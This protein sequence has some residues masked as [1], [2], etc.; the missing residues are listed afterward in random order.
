M[1]CFLNSSCNRAISFIAILHLVLLPFLSIRSSYASLPIAPDGSTNTV[2][3]RSA[4]GIDIV[5]IAAPDSG[6]VSRNNFQDYNVNKSG[7][8]INNASVRDY[9]NGAV[10]TNIAG[11]VLTNSH[12]GNSG[13]ARVILNQVTSNRI[14]RINGYSEIAGR[15]ANLV[16]ANPNGIII[17]GGGFINTDRLG[18]V[19]GREVGAADSNIAINNIDDN[20]Y[21]KITASPHLESG[22]LPKLTISDNGIDLTSVDRTS[23]VANLVEINAGIYADNNKVKI[24]TGD[25]SYSYHKDEVS[26]IDSID[27]PTPSDDLE[28]DEKIAIDAAMLSDIQA[29]DIFLVAT[30]EGFGV[31]YSGAMLASNGEIKVSAD[32]DIYYEN[33]N[34]AGESFISNSQGNITFDDSDTAISKNTEINADNVAIINDSNIGASNIIINVEKDEQDNGNI[35]IDQSSKI[36]SAIDNY[37]NFGDLN[38][39]ANSDINNAGQIISE[40]A[41]SLIVNNGD[42]NLNSSSILSSKQAM[43]LA[44]NNGNIN[45]YDGSEIISGS[46]LSLMASTGGIKQLSKNSVIVHGDHIITANDYINTGK[47]DILGNLTMNIANNLINGSSDDGDGQ[48]AMIFA[49]NDVSLNIGN[50]LINNKYSA[51]YAGNN[52]NIRKLDPNDPN[53]DANNNAVNKVE[54]ISAEIIANNGDINI[55]TK[56]LNNIRSEYRYV[57]HKV[58]PTHFQKTDRPDLSSLQRDIIGNIVNEA[59]IA[60]G[61]NII[62]NTEAF[63]N[64]ASS[65]YAKNDITINANSFINETLDLHSTTNMRAGKK[66]GSC[67]GYYFPIVICYGGGSWYYRQAMVPSGH[68]ERYTA[69]IKAG[70]SINGTVAGNI[71]N[72]T[73]V[74]NYLVTELLPKKTITTSDPFSISTLYESGQLEFD[75]SNYFAGGDT[76]GLIQKSSN[77]NSPLFE[78]RS[79][80]IDQD[81][82]FVSDYFYDKLGINLDDLNTQI[83]QSNSRFIGDQYFQAKIISDQLRSIAR[84]SMLLSADQVDANVEMKNLVDN[85]ADESVRLGLDVNE[86]LTQEQIDL[87]DKDI[88]W[89]ESKIIDGKNYIVPKIYLGKKTRQRLQ[90]DNIGK[91]S[92]IYAKNNINLNSGAGDIVNSGSIIA[93]N[94]INMTSV[95]GDIVNKSIIQSDADIDISGDI[96]IIANNFINTATVATNAKNLLTE[97][98]PAY[99]SNGGEASNEGGIRSKIIATALLT[100]NNI[101]I[102][103]N[104]DVSNIGSEIVSGGNLSI[105]A[106]NDINIE[107]VKLR[108]RYE[109]KW[110]NKKKGG[111]SITDITTNKASNIVSGGSVTFN[112]GNDI[113]VIGSNILASGDATLT[114]GNEINIASAQD[115]YY[116]YEARHKKGLTYAKSSVKINQTTTNKSSNILTN[117]NITITSGNDLNITASNLSGQSGS[118][119]AGIYLDND[120]NSTTFNQI[121]INNDANVNIANAKNTNYTL[122]KKK[123]TKMGFSLKDFATRSIGNHPIYSSTSATSRDKTKT[124]ISNTKEV[125]VK[126]NLNFNNNLAITAAKDLVIKSSDLTTNIGDIDLNATNINILADNNTDVTDFD[127]SV[128]GLFGSNKSDRIDIYGSNAVSANIKAGMAS[129][130]GNDTNGNLNITASNDAILHASYLAADRDVNITVGNNLSLLAAQNI[131]NRSHVRNDETTFNFTNGVSGTTK[132]DIVHNSIFANQSNDATNNQNTNFN[133]GGNTLVQYNKDDGTSL[134]RDIPKLSAKELLMMSEQQ[135]LDYER[136]Y[137]LQVG[138]DHVK[139]INDSSLEADY[140]NKAGLEYISQLD[141]NQTYYNKVS[142]IDESH[143]ETVRGLTENGSAVIAAAAVAIAVGTGGLGSGIS[144]AMMTAAATTAA[145]TTTVAATNS[146]MNKDGDIFK[147]IKDINKDAWDAT[148]SRESVENMAIAAVVAGAGYGIG[149][150]MKAGGVEPGFEMGNID[151]SKIGINVQQGV[152]GKWY[153]KLPN[154][155]RIQVSSLKAHAVGNQNPGFKLLNKTPGAPPFA[156]FHDAMNFPIV[157]NQVSIAPFYAMSQCAA[158]PTLC[159]AF[160]DTFIKI[161]TWGQVDTNLDVNK[162]NYEQNN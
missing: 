69:N 83:Q 58:V 4:N 15:R 95:N 144:G 108:N 76:M 16:I 39:V 142:E 77:P 34:I 129:D 90:N 19:V 159:A 3:D 27:R 81:Q 96:N 63:H 57:E 101:N 53:Y 41:L 120:P 24:L 88:L 87:L 113:N 156:G 9:S 55:N 132:T 75:F 82:F 2:I 23:F 160:P 109:R 61:N 52:L 114:S 115:T 92:T 18:L 74:S 17:N 48:G 147:Q 136:Q 117:G 47:I 42:L 6:G 49:G 79:Q 78:S 62:I 86:G 70:G 66:K 7:L 137:Q 26:S 67:R 73:I 72:D 98:S 89:Y 110:G 80:F 126:S 103:A 5:N 162:N 38:I 143:S 51:I 12:L 127:S 106:G 68:W 22:F 146:S 124:K 32:G 112:A 104:N 99:V 155:E 148:T 150:W 153:Q 29:G 33:A 134:D 21:F 122:S 44:V 161:G 46:S 118:L 25:D 43:S 36:L 56:I 30:K 54:N 85:A 123:K 128:N 71:N 100:G 37:G 119:T 45:N 133:V 138:V 111:K 94:D 59:I 139:G 93:G 8:I 158:A 131:Y 20:L 140:A 64:K 28:S 1:L 14:T 135:R 151:D 60:S 125:V 40:A 35:N 13:S 50:E 121:I 10:N 97:G 11:M 152:D 102:T 65:I 107:T 145:T 116:Y 130:D 154:K 105:S 84:N 149:E 31:K 157:I 91:A 141:P